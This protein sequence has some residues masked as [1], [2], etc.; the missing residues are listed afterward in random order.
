MADKIADIESIERKISNLIDELDDE[1]LRIFQTTPIDIVLF[2]RS[3]DFDVVEFDEKNIEGFILISGD[4]ENPKKLIAVN[5]NLNY[6]DK[7][8]V[9]AHELGHFFLNSNIYS[10]GRI[11]VGARFTHIDQIANRRYNKTKNEQEAA[12]FA[13]CL[14]IPKEELL[15]DWNLY[16]HKK[17]EYQ[18]FSKLLCKKYRVSP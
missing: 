1:K 13:A 15:N 12:Y 9:I 5:K 4:D 10:D 7:R 3:Y 8:F 14:L 2:A 17:E 18:Q 6:E 11:M 16:K